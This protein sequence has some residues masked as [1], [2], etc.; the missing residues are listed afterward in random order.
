MRKKKSPILEAVHQTARGLYK[1]GVMDQVTLREYDR[2]CIP[3]VEPLA[4]D[5]IKQIREASHVSQAVFA[6]L[7]NTS[8]STV[9][10][11]EIGQKKPTGTALKL[12][13]LVQKRGLEVVA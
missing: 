6:R 1:A 13:H 12:L 5:Q 10:K 8:V 9:Q 7:L 4:P 2:L 11:W 3:P